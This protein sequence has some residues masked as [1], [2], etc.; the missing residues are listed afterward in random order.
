MYKKILFIEDE[1]DQIMMVKMRLEASGYKVV[2][3]ADGDEGLKKVHRERPDLILL[4]IIM[5]KIDGYEVCKRLK[6]DPDTR[7]IP[8]I[9]ITASGARGTEEKC[10]ALGADDFIKKP[11]ESADLITKIKALIGQ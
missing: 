6:Q 3:A 2:S 5:P 1:L 7:N 10:R 8:I 4:D 11:F 9:G